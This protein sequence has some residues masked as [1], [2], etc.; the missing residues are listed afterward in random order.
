MGRSVKTAGFLFIVSRLRD[1]DS[2]PHI[3]RGSPPLGDK[4]L[5]ILFPSGCSFSKCGAINDGPS[6]AAQPTNSPAVSH[7]IGTLTAG[8][9]R[10]G[11]FFV[12]MRLR[13]SF[14]QRKEVRDH[15]RGTALITAANFALD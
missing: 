7:C 2:L 10:L 11:V 4:F 6:I 12:Q 15:E 1:L 8:K 13:R 9:R 5:L 3:Y 14:V